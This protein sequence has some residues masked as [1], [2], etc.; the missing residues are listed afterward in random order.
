[1]ADFELLI[2]NEKVK[3]LVSEDEVQY[4]RVKLEEDRYSDT[5]Y[6]LMVVNEEIECVDEDRSL[7]LKWEKDNGTRPDLAG[8]YKSFEKMVLNP[9]DIPKGA[10]IFRIKKYDIVIVVSERL[11]FLFEENKISGVKF[12]KLT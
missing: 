11:K 6:Y 8:E 3:N 5:N 4:I 7:F 2:V 9:T 12:E 10:D 1:M